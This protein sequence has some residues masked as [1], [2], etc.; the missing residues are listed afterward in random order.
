MQL[1]DQNPA[2]LPAGDTL[3]AR[4]AVLHAQEI[5]RALQALSCPPEQKLALLDNILADAAPP[6]AE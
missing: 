2:A 4:V 5:L 3:A 1:D 6:Q